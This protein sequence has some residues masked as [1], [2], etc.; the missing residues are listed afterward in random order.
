MSADYDE[1]RAEN[2]AR[3][4][5]DTAVLALLGHLY[6]ERA[7]FI[8]E[9]LQNA[10]DAGATEIGFE[11]FADRL[12]VRHDGR[13]F[14]VA[15]IRGI[16]GVGQGAKADDLT[17]IGK[18]GIGF[19]AVYA[20]TDSPRIY[21]S[22]ERFR[23]ENYVR[24]YALDPPGEP[25][26]G[27]L[28]VFPFDHP[29]VSAAVAVQE[30]SAALG[31]LD[32]ETLLFLR[33]IERV[34]TGGVLIA[35]TVLERTSTARAGTSRHIAVSTRR[36]AGRST[37]EWLAWHRPLDA[38][39]EPGL[40]VEI[41]IRARPELGGRRLI[42][43][44]TS[45]LVVFFA[46]QKETFLGFLIQGPYRTTPARDNVPEEDR[47]NQA[48]VHQTASL[49]ADVLA[50]LRDDGMLTADV[51]QALPLDASR[52]AP[53]TMFRPL[54]ESARAA[55][56]R[57]ELIPATGGGYRTAP[58]VRL[59]GGAGLRDL[60]TPDLLGELCGSDGPIAFA[61]DSIT[62]TGTP[63]LWR[64]LRDEAGVEEVTPGTV[65]AGL[66]SEF[67]EARS[68][69]WIGLLY[70]FL[71]EH[72]A[73]WRSRRIRAISR[74]RPGRCRSSGSRTAPRWPR[75]TAGA[76]RPLIFPDRSRPGSRRSGGPSPPGRKPGASCLRS[77]SLSRT[78]W[79]RY[80]TMC[81]PAT[82]MPMSRSWM[83]LSTML[84]SNWSRA[85]SL[86]CRRPR[87]SGC[88]SSCGRPRS[89]SARTRR[90]ARAA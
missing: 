3:Y 17:K 38:L 50:E 63:L 55:V 60:L 73:L 74:E 65:A 20:Y 35:G 2:I 34:R 13:P 7:H 27:T 8:F 23:I 72:Q 69:Q 89:W 30:I 26:A 82:T 51:L 16:C 66:T 5:W 71:D 39:G 42:R 62:E 1:I 10:E 44:G 14:T 49:L 54:F 28:F 78:W 4:G 68:D 67:L 81:C 24:P 48:L 45:P 52:F 56:A 21:S 57:D 19:K 46:T 18:F 53:G 75:S 29:G 86:R 76:G 37:D 77:A 59:A 58:Q 6:S 47:W 31:S 33:S 36:D 15:D 11:L 84:I 64:Y 87:E 70:G 80:S 61:D 41:A 32:A 83:R 25:V 88:L 40:Q 12:E 22:G 90:P 85:H 79:L 43:R 9:L